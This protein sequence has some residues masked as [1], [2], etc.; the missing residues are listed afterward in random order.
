MDERLVIYHYEQ[1]VIG[2]GSDTCCHLQCGLIL[3]KFSLKYILQI[4]IIFMPT[5]FQLVSVR[6]TKDFLAL[7][8]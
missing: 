7:A 8:G 4:I 5:N 3:F 2:C 6:E 1:F